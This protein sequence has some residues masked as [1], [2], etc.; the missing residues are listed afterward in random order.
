[1]CIGIVWVLLGLLLK[2]C[3]CYW[4][5]GLWIELMLIIM[6]CMLKV[7]VSFL[8]N[9]GCLSVGELIDI[10]LVL[11]YSMWWVVFML[12]MLLVM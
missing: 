3:I 10:L 6:Y 11:V 5:L 8:I 2:W 9:V 12:L 7:L 1:M 4:L